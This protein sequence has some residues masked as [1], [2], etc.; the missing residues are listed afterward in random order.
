MPVDYKKRLQLKKYIQRKAE[1]VRL[2]TIFNR[3]RL[4]NGAFQRGPQDC[5]LSS[6]SHIEGELFLG[7]ECAYIL[8]FL[9]QEKAI[10]V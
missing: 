4:H 6:N 2:E 1:C 5:S 3:K 9:A 10:S 8:P 7:L